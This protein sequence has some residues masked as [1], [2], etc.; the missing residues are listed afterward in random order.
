MTG[1]RI[2]AVAA[3]AP[4]PGLSRLAPPAAGGRRAR[5]RRRRAGGAVPGDD[6]DDARRRGR[7]WRSRRHS[8]SADETDGPQPWRRPKSRRNTCACIRRRV[9][10]MVW[11]GR[12]SRGSAR[13]SAITGATRI[14]R[15]RR[16]ARSTRPGPAGRCSSS[17]RPGRS[18][19]WP[20]A[21]GAPD[22]WNPADAIYGAANYLRA[23]G[24]PGNYKAAIYAYNHAWWYVE[25]VES[26]AAKYR[27]SSTCRR[28][29]REAAQEVKAVGD[30]LTGAD[31]R[32]AS[33][34]DTPVRFIAGEQA[35]ARS[36]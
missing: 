33:E 7:V 26:W 32:L 3:E 2:A 8:R 25:E 23:S 18:T 16:R 10:A 22:R 13:S 24:A 12:C 28:R 5:G 20:P 30:G 14:R 34:T 35:R 15:A 19:G 21:G 17:P 11:T 36:R 1:V 9:S 27:G 6:A 31:T 29:V 4:L